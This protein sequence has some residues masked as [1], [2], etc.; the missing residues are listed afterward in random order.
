[1]AFVLVPAVLLAVIARLV[2]PVNRMLTGTGTN[3]YGQQ[4][5]LAGWIFIAAFF[6]LPLSLAILWRRSNPERRTRNRAESDR[7]VAELDAGAKLSPVESEVEALDIPAD[8]GAPP[9]DAA[10]V[11]T[12][13]RRP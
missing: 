13:A 9:E 10:P 7:I 8:Q 5:A 2:D 1:M 11:S 3:W 6:W 4:R 12:P